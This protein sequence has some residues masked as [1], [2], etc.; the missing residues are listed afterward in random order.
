LL[1][2]V[3][4]CFIE[5]QT[6]EDIVKTKEKVLESILVGVPPQ[7]QQRDIDDSDSEPAGS[8]QQEA[9]NDDVENVQDGAHSCTGG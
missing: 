9:E 4:L 3:R 1:E 5:D 7:R 6:I 8:A 2:A